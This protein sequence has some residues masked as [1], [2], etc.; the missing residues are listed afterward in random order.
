VSSGYGI[1]YDDA[2]SQL[3]H[4]LGEACGLTL[5][6]TEDSILREEQGYIVAT[7]RSW[8]HARGARQVSMGAL[9][10]IFSSPNDAGGSNTWALVFFLY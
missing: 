10:K 7:V 3:V 8:T 4:N 1:K 2:L 6:L 5:I 9:A